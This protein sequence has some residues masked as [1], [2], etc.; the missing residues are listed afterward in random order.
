M[1]QASFL[2]LAIVVGAD[3]P[4]GSIGAEQGVVPP[5]LAFSYVPVGCAGGG[6]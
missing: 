1:L 3:E 4:Y 6:R 5:L 2:R